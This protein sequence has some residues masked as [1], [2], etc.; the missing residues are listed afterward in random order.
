MHTPA[1]QS[2]DATAR[3]IYVEMAS[4][5]GGPGS[6]NGC[7]PYSVREAA[8]SLR[9]GKTTAARALERLQQRGFIVPMKKGAFSWKLRH[10]TEWRLTE[11]PCDLNSAPATKEF[12]RWCPEIQNAVPPQTQMVPATEPVG[13]SKG[14]A[15]AE[16]SRN[17]TCSGTLVVYQW[18]WRHYAFL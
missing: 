4:R 16:M 6:N 5:Y 14:T 17:G 3:A 13:T 8:S 11:F 7:I 12:M 1:W 18:G 10:S 2:L 15:V 9:I